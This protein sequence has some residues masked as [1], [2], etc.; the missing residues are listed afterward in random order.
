MFKKFFQKKNGTDPTSVN[1]EQNN[2]PAK[3]KDFFSNLKLQLKKKTK[4]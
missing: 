1:T 2:K 4:Y 3:L